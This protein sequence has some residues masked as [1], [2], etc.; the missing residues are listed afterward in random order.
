[1]GQLI[2]YCSIEPMAFLALLSFQAALLWKWRT[3]RR[4]AWS[5]CNL[6]Y[7]ENPEAEIMTLGLKQPLAEVPLQSHTAAAATDE[8]T[9][10]P[11]LLRRTGLLPEAWRQEIHNEGRDPWLLLQTIAE[12]IRFGI[13]LIRRNPLLSAVVVLTLTVGIGINASIFTVYSAVAM[14]TH[15]SSSPETFLRI[16]PISRMQGTLRAASFAEYGRLRD[17]SRTVRQLAAVSF[18]PVMMGDDDLTDNAGLAVSCNFF[19]VEGLDRP[20]MGRL[21][22][23][24]DCSAP[25][26]LPVVVIDEAMWHSR[27]ASDPHVIGRTAHINSRPVVVVGVIPNGTSRWIASRHAGVWLPYTAITYFD[28]AHD[29]FHRE[30]YLAFDLAGRLRPGYTRDQA[31]A[32]MRILE[33]RQD[34]QHSGRR[35]TVSVTDGS[36]SEEWDL[37]ASVRDLMLMGFFFATFNLVL[38]IACANVATLLLSRAA[39]RRREIAV[40]LALGVARV[41]LIRMLITESLLLAACAGLASFYLVWHLPRPL[42]TYLSPQPPDFPMPPDWR[43]FAYIAA[44]VAATGILAGLA[45]A[46]ESL[47][48]DLAAS[49]KGS[50]SGAATLLGTG[51]GGMRLRG[52]LVSAQVAFSMVLLVEAGLFARTEQRALSS[53][54]GYAPG[55]VVVAFLR[56]PDSLKPELAPARLDTIAQRMKR[57]PGVRSVSFSDELPLV[58]PRTVELRPP[59]RRD[60][61]QPIDVY[62]AS[63]GFFATLGLPIVRGREFNQADSAAVIVS[64][65]MAKVFWPR[66]DPIG[67]ILQLPEGAVPVV[68]VA[69][70]VD[71]M[72]LGGSDNPPVYRLRH[73]D[74]HRN[75]MSVRFDS[76]V[77][78][79]ALAV[80]SALRESDPD[81]FVY[82]L[83]LQKWI[84]QIMARLWSVASLIV[85]LGIVATV[86]ATTGI[87]GAVSFAVNQR[88]RELGIRVALG[89]TRSDI[90]REVFL[91]SGK[92]VLHGLIAGLWLAVPTAA[93]LRESV[94][95]S[96]LRLDNGEPLLYAGAA[97]LLAVAAILAMV[98]PAR[99]GAGSDP[100]D[101]LRCE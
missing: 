14:R 19:A 64:Q 35:T 46:I 50:P 66:Q 81:L 42:Y 57:L 99:R 96:P 23:P 70:D 11:T 29:V 56:F 58:R 15:V 89:A 95:G 49:L 84:D 22:V 37:R 65:T 73:A 48:V 41:R 5:A 28:P 18:I 20:V 59:T 25:G 8:D 72:R 61:S 44:V 68:G 100:L 83:P 54:P 97:I 34:R 82:P 10:A 32:E 60:A 69:G 88:M 74:P 77:T 51:T 71:S 7:E 6:C 21:F 30:D 67:R 53:D 92:P 33:Q 52:F 98:G 85:V 39:A 79:G 40:R 38:F 86:L 3:A 90:V 27:F 13:R 4:L 75:V 47:K 36:W 9:F 26:Q 16:F 78:S 12:D 94:R 55:K 24:D 87:Y 91:S 17:E 80:R 62:T 63:T 101:A 93:G 2:L 1:V 31:Q 76:D 43:T 45:P